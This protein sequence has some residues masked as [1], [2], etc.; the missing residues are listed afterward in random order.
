MQTN[1]MTNDEVNRYIA[2]EIMKLPCF[3]EAENEEYA[4]VIC[5]LCRNG[6]GGG[7]W[8]SAN[9]DYCSDDSPRS[10][11]NEVVAKVGFRDVHEQLDI[12]PIEATAEQIARAC[13]KAYQEQQNAD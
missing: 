2:I 4:T 7:A 1:E 13:V 10:L 8:S 11:L 6:F 12:I 3:H 5:R 9:P